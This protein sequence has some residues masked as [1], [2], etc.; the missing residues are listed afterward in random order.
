M[1]QQ[2]KTDFYVV[3]ALFVILGVMIGYF[4]TYNLEALSD[5]ATAV[6]STFAAVVFIIGLKQWFG[7]K[8]EKGIR[9]SW[10]L[11]AELSLESRKLLGQMEVGEFNRENATPEEEMALHDLLFYLDNVMRLHKAGFLSEEH[12]DVF[13]WQYLTVSRNEDV[14]EYLREMEKGARSQDVHVVPFRHFRESEDFMEVQFGR[15]RNEQN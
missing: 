3:A 1:E 13:A 7:W 12:L 2:T 14:Q 6:A 10:E 11:A 5:F 15:R 9:T 4:L 8:Y